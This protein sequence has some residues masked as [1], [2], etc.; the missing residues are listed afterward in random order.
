MCGP[1]KDCCH[2]S[3]ERIRA[4]RSSS[5]ARIF[6][7]ARRQPSPQVP[8]RRVSRFHGRRRFGQTTHDR[9]RPPHEVC[10]WESVPCDFGGP[11]DLPVSLPHHLNGVCAA[12]RRVP[13]CSRLVR[14]HTQRSDERNAHLM[15]QAREM[16]AGESVPPQRSSI[17]RSLSWYDNQCLLT[18]VLGGSEVA[19]RE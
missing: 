8:T 15:E 17:D 5:R 3:V 1:G 16:S 12:R 4:D 18:K 10:L 19:T 14:K 11:V 6:G 7:G 2:Y 9:R 13:S